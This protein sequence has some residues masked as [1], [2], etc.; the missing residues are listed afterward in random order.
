MDA[1][2]LASPNM[3]N[4]KDFSFRNVVGEDRA[5]RGAL[6]MNDDWFDFSAE[7]EEASD[8]NEEEQTA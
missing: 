1:G 2:Y 6:Q 8:G 7:R 4:D 3:F 5:L